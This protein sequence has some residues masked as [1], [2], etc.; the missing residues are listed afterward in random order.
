MQIAFGVT[1]RARP[2]HDGVSA[3][4]AERPGHRREDRQC[5]GGAAGA[6]TAHWGFSSCTGASD[7][8]PP[9]AF[10]TLVMMNSTRRF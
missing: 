3:A 7:V 9:W 8:D 6:M 10:L 2:A 5:G 1:L 4:C